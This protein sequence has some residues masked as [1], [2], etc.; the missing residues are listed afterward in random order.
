MKK[1]HTCSPKICCA[2]CSQKTCALFVNLSDRANTE[3]TG[4]CA[5]NYKSKP[6]SRQ[7]FTCERAS[8]FKRCWHLRHDSS[9]H[10]SLSVSWRK[11]IVSLFFNLPQLA[12]TESECVSASALYYFSGACSH[13]LY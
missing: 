11:H 12:W 9:V 8:C 2:I 13:I 10:L 6:S 7:T 3:K 4:V 1:D 5:D